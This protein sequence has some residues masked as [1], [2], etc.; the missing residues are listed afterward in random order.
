MNKKKLLKYLKTF[1][2]LALGVFFIFYS[3][4]GFTPE[5]RQKLFENIA[6]VN[7]LWVTLALVGGLLS[8][9]SRAYRW[10]LLLE[11]LGY[12]IRFSTAFMG[13]MSGYLANLGI[14]RS[15]EVLRGA[16]AATYDNIPF[17]KAFGTIIAE[18][19]VDVVIAFT[20]V[21]IAILLHTNEFFLFFEEYNIN[22]WFSI[23]G[24]V[25]LILMGSL[26]FFII[27]KSSQP[28][29]IKVRNFFSGILQGVKSIL[30]MKNTLAFI[31]HTLF[32]WG[33][34]VLMFYIL[35]F[36]FLEMQDLSFPTMLTAFIVGSFSISITNGGVGIYP[37][38]VGATFALFDISKETGEAFGW[39]DWS[40]Q[41]ILSIVI[42]GFSLLLL[43]VLNKKKK[44]E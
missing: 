31:L 35:K 44:T 13:I 34:Y 10:K 36:A 23:I 14:P 28:I 41:T 15:G 40:L 17:E 42:G 32:I 20:L 8:H 11:P 18:R 21:F 39:V 6:E 29:F 43:P 16:T 26:I 12:K 27:K 25:I 9:M 4:Y 5:E 37:V 7:P 22:P 33:M 1:L 19:A 3:Y 24:L 38:A 2:P 30:H